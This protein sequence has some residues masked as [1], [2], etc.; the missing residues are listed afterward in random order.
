[1]NEWKKFMY[2]TIVSNY[3]EFSFRARN[4]LIAKEGIGWRTFL[5]ISLAL[6]VSRFNDSWN[7]I[8]IY[9]LR[10]KNMDYE[11]DREKSSLADSLTCV[12]II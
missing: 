6:R 1:M 2:K 8:I 7:P 9:F 4:I 12:I 10:V 3:K 11:W 5:S